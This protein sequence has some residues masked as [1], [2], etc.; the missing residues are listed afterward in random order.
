MKSL[1]SNLP[2]ASCAFALLPLVAATHS[3]QTIAETSSASHVEEIVVTARK[4]EENLLQVPIS[5]TTFGQQRLSS[6]LLQ[7]LSSL[8]DFT[9]N[10]DINWTSPFSGSSNAASVFIR[11]V[12]QNDFIL[13]T[14]PG[15]GIYLDGVYIA[16]SIG[17]VLELTD[18]ERVEILRGPQGTL[19][20]K[21][22]IGGAIQVLSKTPS[23]ELQGKISLIAGEDNRRDFSA[24]LEG[25]LAS[26]IQAR[27]TLASEHR[28]GHST[29]ILDNKELGDIDR[30]AAK[31]LITYQPTDNSQWQL[32]LDHTKQRQEAI[33]QHV[34]EV[35]DST[36]LMDLFNALVAP[37]DGPFDS[38]WVSQDVSKNYQT[39][40]SRDDLNV[41]GLSLSGEYAMGWGELISITGYRRYSAVYSRDPDGSPLDYAH[42]VNRDTHHQFSQ[43]VRLQ[44]I[45]LNDKLNWVAGI[46]HLREHGKNHT[47]A[48][49]WSGLY[50]ATGVPG[51]EWVFDVNNDLTTT[52]TALFSQASYQLSDALSVTGGIRMTHEEKEF[53]V[54]NRRA[55]SGTQVVGPTEVDDQWTNI[56]PMAS[57]DYR[58]SPEFMTYLSASR[59]FKSGGFDGRQIMPGPVEAYDPEFAET[60]EMGFKASF[61]QQ[62]GILTGAVFHT[63][64]EDLQFTQL[65]AGG[66][67]R[68]NNAAEARIKGADMELTLQDLYG[69]NLQA[70]LGYLDARYHSLDQGVTITEDMD[71]V[72]VPRWNA[73]LSLS[74]SWSLSGIGK[75]TL[76][77]DVSYKSKVYHDPHNVESIAQDGL[78]LANASLSWSSS[79]NDWE[80][81]AFVTNLTDKDYWVSGG[82]ELAGLGYSEVNYARGREWGVRL[83]YQY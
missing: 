45:S 75:V 83:S 33:A 4:R 29:R 80:A 10:V 2:L 18:I 70:G 66:I 57:V 73:H 7:D 42:S 82:T 60:F 12:G 1:P 76:N 16:R 77:T 31:L 68:I 3:V 55:V 44:G 54:D 25:S 48:I 22:S 71:L 63:A 27:L 50:E 32:S 52:S 81:E 74:R 37:A 20:G 51:L 13:T 56:S 6:P 5:M 39:G 41:T 26:N 23:D 9:P 78:T 61:W 53:L 17:S 79:N 43:E 8:A 35:V 64:Y 67:P 47:D 11:G 72:R 69:L 49:L 28:D 30:Q 34:V 58:W 62:R 38:R 59:G 14:D 36:P 46:Y 19:F 24:S 21:N 40:P 15:V 65:D